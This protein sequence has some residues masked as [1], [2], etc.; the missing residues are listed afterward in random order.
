MKF[1]NEG[2]LPFYWQYPLVWFGLLT[3][4]REATV[5]SDLRCVQRFLCGL[6]SVAPHNNN[7]PTLPLGNGRGM[8]MHYDCSA[9]MSDL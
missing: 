6:E 1:I 9:H 8:G 5:W 2:P 7:I 4:S 3:S